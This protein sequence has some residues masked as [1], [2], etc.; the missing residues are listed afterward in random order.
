M[1]NQICLRFDKLRSYLPDDLN[2]STSKDIH[3]LGNIK[4]Y[5]PIVGS[6][7]KCKTE[8]DKINAGFLWLFEQNIINRITGFKGSS[9]KKHKVFIIYIMIWLSYMLSLKKVNN[10][11]NLNEF[12]ELHI[13]DNTHYNTCK[14]YKNNNYNDCSNSLKDKTGYNNFKEFIEANK[15]L[16]NIGIDDVSNLYA[17]LKSLCKMYTEV[18]ANDRTSKNYLVKANE[19]VKKYDELNKHPNIT[20]YSP[21]YQVLST[22]SNDYNNFKNYCKENQFDC[23]DIQS[24]SPI[25]IKENSIQDSGQKSEVTSSSSSITNKLIPVLSIIVAIP[26]F[27]GIFYK[28]SLFGFRKR[29]QKQKLREK[30]KK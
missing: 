14:K 15:C 19:F 1:D 21:Y 25:K 13:K 16:M 18:D 11:N 29:F 4:N 7:N 17:A 6:E 24:I 26:I 30:L 10:I 27:L 3:G 12:Y 5:C 2:N 22:L 28:Y 9:D 20:K 23:D 8:A